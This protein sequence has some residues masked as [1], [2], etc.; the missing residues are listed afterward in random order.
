MIF[1]RIHLDS[2]DGAIFRGDGAVWPLSVGE[3]KLLISYYYF[4]RILKEWK[5]SET[6]QRTRGDLFCKFL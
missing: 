3:I 6:A 4:D 1:W 2:F 5:A